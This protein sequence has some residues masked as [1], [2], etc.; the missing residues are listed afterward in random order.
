MLL[1][2]MKIDRFYLIN[3]FDYYHGLL[4]Q[5]QQQYFI[6][7]YF[8][9]QSLSEI[10]EI[11]NVSRMAIQSSIKSII[12][13]LQKYESILELYKLSKLRLNYYKKINDCELRKNLLK[14]E[15]EKIINEKQN[16]Q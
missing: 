7:Y 14:L 4:T 3:L 2:S 5:K 10:S 13:D 6:R 15:K 9:D 1:N 8:E 16:N 12:I 11:Y